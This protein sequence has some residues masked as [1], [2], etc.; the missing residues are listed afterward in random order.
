MAEE[1]TEMMI[2]GKKVKVSEKVLKSRTMREKKVTVEI[3]GKTFRCAEHML[4][5]MARFGASQTKRAIKNPPKEVVMMMA[6]KQ[7]ILPATPKEEPL[8]ELGVENMT[9]EIIAEYPVDI[10]EVS[11]PVVKTRKTRV[12]SK[13]KK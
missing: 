10:P 12:V 3:N 2:E 4:A 7:I 5:D 11:T 6:P 9:K 8:V 13:S 1:F